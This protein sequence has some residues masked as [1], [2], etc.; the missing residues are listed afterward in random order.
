[1]RKYTLKDYVNNSNFI[2]KM[3]LAFSDLRAD[4]E[5]S[6]DADHKKI[7]EL[8]ATHVDVRNQLSNLVAY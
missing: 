3:N 1:M 4:Y 6:M 5:L 8:M 2:E 7:S